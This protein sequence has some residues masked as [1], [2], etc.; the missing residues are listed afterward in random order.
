MSD[1]EYGS[2]GQMPD[3][4]FRLRQAR[5]A[6]GLHVAALAGALKV[7][8]RKL[9]ALEEGRYGELPDLTFARAL[10]SSV[11]RHLGVDPG[12]V[13]DQIPASRAPT[14]GEAS[15]GLNAP[16][17]VPRDGQ[18]ASKVLEVLR[19][20]AVVI[21]LLLLLGAGV[22][23]LVPDFKPMV[24]SLPGELSAAVE[25]TLGQVNSVTTEVERNAFPVPAAD[26]SP[27]PSVAIA[28]QPVLPV[29][30]ATPATGT[31]ASATA[32]DVLLSI[33]ATAESWVEVVDGA[34]VSQTQ[35]MLQPGDVLEFGTSPPYSVV[36]G[37]ADSVEVRVRGQVFDVMPYARNSVAR[38]QVK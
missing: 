24:V 18:G 7:P 29:P 25:S 17:K 36:V 21:S 23:M 26:A 38:F 6:A 12:P 2:A 32:S 33:R 9:E 10:A 1:A 34:G 19:R 13:L 30:P 8:Q 31:A 3:R 5:E 16:F 14:L 20:P 37:R 15:E 22:L 28:A 35:R 27:A 4:P 11:C